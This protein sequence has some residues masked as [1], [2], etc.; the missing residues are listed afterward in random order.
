MTEVRDRTSSW[1]IKELSFRR[2][3]VG[4]RRQIVDGAAASGMWLY[5]KCDPY[6]RK[7]WQSDI[8]DGYGTTPP[9]TFALAYKGTIRVNVSN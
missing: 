9:A 6:L 1:T 3:S 5:R 4:I 2:H 7:I 8:L